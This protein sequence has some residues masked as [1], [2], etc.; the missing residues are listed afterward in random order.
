MLAFTNRETVAAS[1]PTAFSNRFQPGDTTLALASV[2]RSGNS[3]A[4][5]ALQ[6]A[7]TDDQA[8]QVL[9]PV[10]AGTQ[11]VLV[12]LHGNNNAPGDCF[13]RCARLEEIYGVSVIAFS[14]ASEGLLPS[15]QDLVGLSAAGM[16]NDTEGGL[17]AV[18]ASNR[19]KGAIQSKIRRYHQAK[20]NASDSIDA[21]ARMLRLLATA[22]LYAHVQ[23]MS[24]A[25][26]SLGAH[27]LQNTLELTGAKEALGAMHNISLLAACCRA[28]GHASWLAKLQPSGQVFVSFNAADSV[29]YGARIAD[30]NQ[31]KLGAEPGVRLMSPK[32]RYISFTNAQLDFGG[33][34]YF[35]R[36]A[37][38]R[39]PKDARKV[40]SRQ[41]GSERDIHQDQGEEPKKV[42]PL[43]C[44]A[45]GATCYMAVA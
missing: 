28:S 41:F 18:N 3:F 34:S 8:L 31:I 27:F 25:A 2:A 45:D 30:H 37:G 12:Y 42:Y 43:G 40:F 5:S 14:W 11:R 36:D 23:P 17:A 32:V 24:L 13:E 21:L 38:K 6:A 22:R 1:D 29:L 20:T 9:V 19:S 10:F 7:I 26:H 15:G 16:A 35:I 39:V 4:V 33:H 44:D